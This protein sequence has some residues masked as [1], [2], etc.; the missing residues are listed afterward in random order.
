MHTTRTIL[1]LYA[2]SSATNALARSGTP[3]VWQHPRQMSRP[4]RRHAI[5]H[6]GG[7]RSPILPP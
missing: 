1:L 7:L 4:S 5:I 2:Y 3:S 6:H